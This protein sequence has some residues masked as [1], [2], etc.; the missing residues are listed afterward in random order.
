[1]TGSALDDAYTA[2]VDGGVPAAM[3]GTDT[4]LVTGLAEGDH[5]VLLGDVYNVAG[6]PTTRLFQNFAIGSELFHKTYGEPG[7]VETESFISTRDEA[8]LDSASRTRLLDWADDAQHG[9]VVYTARPSLPP[10]DL[11]SDTALTDT[12]FGYAPEA[13]LALD[14][15]GLTGRVPLIG[16]GRVGWLAWRSGR[17]AAD[18]VKPSPVQA[19]AAVGAIP[20]SPA[21]C[22]TSA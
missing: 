21:T 2:T 19:L 6:T 9:V 1:T 8:L 22:A 18:Y 15:L 5:E 16:Q 14:L 13:E 12:N 20:R 11:A 4:L 7:P 17:T 3:T 10:A